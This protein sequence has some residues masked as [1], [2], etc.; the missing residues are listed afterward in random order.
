M[1]PI[2][3]FIARP[4]ATTLLT[5]GV[6][7]AGL[8]A[9]FQLP[10]AP[11]PQVEFPTISVNA[12]LPGAS[13]ETMAATVAT[14]LERA[15]GAISGV[16][17]I[18]SYSTQSGTR[19]T[20]QFE[21]N[22][23]IDSAA[24]DVAAA[25]QA[26]LPMLPSGMPSAPGYRKVNPADSPI[27]ILSLTSDV[28]SRG[29]LYD[30]ASTLLAQRL[31]QVEGVG[32]VTLGGGALP[33]VRIELDP[34]RLLAQ[35][36]ALEDV[37]MAVVAHHGNRP[38]G[39]LDD[40]QRSW[41]IETNGQARKAAD[42][43]PL[44]LR[45]RDG[46]A[47]RLSDVAEV[48]DSVQD[49]RNYG[50]TNGR[51]AITLMLQKQPDANVLQVVDRVYGLMPQLQAGLP[52][53]VDLRVVLDRTP[54]LRAS[55][56]E[57][58]KS[59]AVSVAL[60][61]LVVGLFLRRLR[62][63][64]I[65]T[66]AVPV[67]LAGAFGVMYLLGYSLNNLS[68]M[69]LTIA[70]GFVVDDAIVVL[71]NVTRRL[72]KGD[73]PWQAALR[74][75]REIAVTVV[76]ISLSL[77]AA[78]IPVLLMGGVLGRL[79]QEFAVV[80]CAAI[81][82]SM[83]VS[84]TTTPMMCAALLT[85]QSRVTRRPSRWRRFYAR[86]LSWSLRHQPVLW[87]MLLAV[88][89]LNVNLYQVIP[90]GFFPQQDTGRIFG[91]I[92]ADQSS[93]FQIM[94]QRLDR[95]IDIVRTDPAVQDV[96]GYTG[97]FQRNSAWMSISLKPRDERD[98][99][100]DQVVTRLRAKLNSEPGARLF[101]VPGQDL[102]FGARTS[103]SQFEYT[104]KADDLEDLKVWAPLIRQTLMRLKD[105]EDVATEFEDRGLQTSL[106]IDR[107]AIARLGLS[108]RD[109]STALQNALGQRQ[110]GI[111]YNPLNQYRVVLEIAPQHLADEQALRRLH[112]INNQG[113][114][115]PLSS[116]ARLELT[117]A[118]L[119]VGHDGGVPSDTFSFNLAPGVSLSQA[120]QSVQR[121]LDELRMPISVRGSF[122]GSASAFQRSLESQPLLILLALVTLYL[123]LGMLYE[124]LLHPLTILSTLPSAGVGALLALLLTGTE[125][126]LIAL[127][128]VI[129]LIGI[130]KKNAILMIDLA[131][132]HQRAGAAASQAILRAALRRARPIFMTT[133][134]AMLGALPLA[135]GQ[136]EGAE[137]RRPLGLSVLGGLLLSQLLTL[138]T[139]PVVFLAVD[140]CRERWLVWRQRGQTTALWRY[141]EV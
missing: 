132:Q 97:G 66:V 52:A 69:A 47:V 63:A 113:Q 107:E 140:R 28:L 87:L 53:T 45:F 17:E 138:Y 124:S 120:T 83:V 30:L 57:I 135:L 46:R 74:G 96:T 121:A 59:L 3:L 78:F 64:V 129:L 105:I 75:S 68:L 89:A 42:F 49:L 110:V 24:R 37:R 71:E 26:A 29:E 61:I 86:T 73:T 43:T 70:T 44:V 118:A 88:I 11:L 106:V 119:G 139:T 51:P 20:L 85:P 111:I 39:A 82:I 95:F 5:L 137:L 9:Y 19:V 114:A 18:T 94:Q 1:N 15:L 10:V 91:S 101:M 92:R 104:V 127:I 141:H 93:S 128:G 100:A 14:P 27:L 134:A 34:D 84:L 31:S 117:N 13:P 125:F 80:L 115:V 33:A 12:S 90:K 136:A 25:I 21:L 41:Q 122:S 81:L 7:M 16:T 32:Q 79:F 35:G 99:S 72:E 48:L 40:G 56:F 126:S 6:A 67:S 60:V 23:H 4:V 8:L 65:P 108:M 77:I 103:S 123:L 2:A 38:K 112:F 76:I 50:A 130:V 58:Q 36:L 131:L 54:N 116:F 98:A 102:R 62:A 109:I 55:I 133:L 22:R